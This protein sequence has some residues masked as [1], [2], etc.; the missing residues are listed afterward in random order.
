MLPIWIIGDHEIVNFSCMRFDDCVPYENK[1][2]SWMKKFLFYSLC[3]Q[4]ALCSIQLKIWEF[5][6]LSLILMNTF[7][8]NLGGK[9]ASKCWSNV[10]VF[11]EKKRKDMKHL[12]WITQNEWSQFVISN[13]HHRLANLMTLDPCRFH[14][15]CSIAFPILIFLLPRVILQSKYKRYHRC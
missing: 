6:T 8:G 2:H 14:W 9:V 4:N 1:L 10:C 5:L 13:S 15:I 11:D 12:T 3:L 7:F